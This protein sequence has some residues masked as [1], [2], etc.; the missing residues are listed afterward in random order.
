[1]TSDA[2]GQGRMRAY[3]Q[4]S[5]VQW[6]ACCA[7]LPGWHKMRQQIRAEG[8]LPLLGWRLAAHP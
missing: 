6:L 1:M 3:R 8:L 7:G 4:Q 2:A 5:D